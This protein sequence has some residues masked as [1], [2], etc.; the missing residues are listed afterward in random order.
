MTVAVTAA[1][2]VYGEIKVDQGVY[3]DTEDRTEG[4]R[5]LPLSESQWRTSRME[6]EK[7]PAKNMSWLTKDYFVLEYGFP[8]DFSKLNS[9]DKISGS[10]DVPS[11]I[12]DGALTF[13]TSLSCIRS[14]RHA[15]KTASISGNGSKTFC[16]V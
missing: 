9:L 8:C 2:S 11:K 1:L 4:L 7:F 14:P 13:R 6:T 3:W 15:K 5:L 12:K 16:L 10:V